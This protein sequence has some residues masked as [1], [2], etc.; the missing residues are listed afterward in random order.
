MTRAIEELKWEMKEHPDISSLLSPTPSG[1]LP[2]C[3][4][5]PGRAVGL[6]CAKALR[7]EE[8]GEVGELEE[9][10]RDKGTDSERRVA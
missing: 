6:A 5:V 9:R 4:P 2:R 10:K 3:Y 7:Q 1:G 8:A